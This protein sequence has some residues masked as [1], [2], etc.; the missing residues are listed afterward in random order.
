MPRT[1]LAA[2]FGVLLATATLAEGPELRGPATV[3]DGDGLIVSGTEI[4]LQGIAAPERHAPGGAEATGA[5]A[6]LIEDHTVTCRPDGTFT[7]GRTVAICYVDGRD[8]AEVLIR[9]GYARDCPR[10]SRGRYAPAERAARAD[11]HDASRFY[12]LPGYCG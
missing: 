2:A 1:A 6:A 11:G 4:R 9:A 8:V 7:R 5:L 12:R 3:V 10:Y